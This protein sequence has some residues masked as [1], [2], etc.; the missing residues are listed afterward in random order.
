[1]YQTRNLVA[2]SV[3]SL[4]IAGGI[5]LAALTLMNSATQPN[6]ALSLEAK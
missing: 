3:H 1:M 5:P 4:A 6:A 2:A